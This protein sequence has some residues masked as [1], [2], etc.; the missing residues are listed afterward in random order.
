M[1]YRSPAWLRGGHT[2][3]LWP[4][5]LKGAAPVFYRERWDTPDGD[6][7]DVDFLPYQPGQPLVTLFH[8]LEGSSRSHYARALMRALGHKGWN[9]AVVHFRGCSGEPNRLARAYHS[10]DADE[11]DWVLTRLAQRFADHRRYAVGVSLGGNALLCWLGTREAAA[12]TRVDKA[13]SVSAPLDLTLSGYYLERGFNKVYTRHFLRTLQA[14]AQFKAQNHPGLFDATRA[15]SARTLYEFDDAY[16]A[17]MHGF[18][19]AVEYWRRASSKP[20]LRGIAVP[21]LILNARNDPFMPREVLPGRHEVSPTVVLEQPA[22]G[23]HVGFASGP[24]PGH[25]EWLPRRLLAFFED[26][27]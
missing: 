5:A 3:T 25:I 21:T 13:A 24:F 9:G 15:A 22:E 11:I 14:A 18:G 26:A 7:I 8:G 6:F 16:T 17:P 1:S 27:R 20:L 23:G 2:Q 19:T 12:H 4:L 10:G